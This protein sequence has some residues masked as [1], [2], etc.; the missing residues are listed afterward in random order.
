VDE[1]S[2]REAGVSRVAELESLWAAM[3][4]HHAT[5]EAKLAP[6]DGG[7]ATWDVGERVAELES[8]SVAADARSQEVG[9]LLLGAAREV[10]RRAGAERLQVGVAHANANAA[11]F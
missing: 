7:P 3:H 8:L 6:G 5:M 11:R 2:I 1:I 4:S 10:A 9:T